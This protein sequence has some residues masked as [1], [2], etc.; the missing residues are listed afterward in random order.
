VI[1]HSA[2]LE[3]W[4]CIRRP[5]GCIGSSTSL[6]CNQDHQI[7]VS[8]GS[9]WQSERDPSSEKPLILSGAVSAQELPSIKI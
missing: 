2:L 8:H 3:R 4:A 7:V 6:I 1:N 5:D 9:V